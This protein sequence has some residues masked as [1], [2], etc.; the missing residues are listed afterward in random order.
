MYRIVDVKGG[1]HMDDK[2]LT[3]LKNL[4]NISEGSKLELI[5]NTLS[6]QAPL[7]GRVLTSIKIHRL[8]QRLK[9]HENKIND[10]NHR[11]EQ[12][13]DLDFVL[14]IKEF[15][16]PKVLQDLLDEDEDNKIAYF[17]DGFGQVID[18]EIYD[19][20]KI[21]IFYDILRTLRFIEI[22][23]LVSLTSQFKIYN[24]KN[25]HE[26]GNYP[27]SIFNKP[28]FQRIKYAIENKLESLG[29]IE[30]GRMVSYE[31][32]MD[33][34]DE[35]LKMSKRYSGFYSPRRDNTTEIAMFGYDFLNFF[36]ILD[37]YNEEGD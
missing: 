34:F 22:E 6:D 10:I 3:N 27:E 11:V 2:T 36:Y 19:K 16:L 4:M 26:H 15:L 17:L 9:K 18:N 32:V 21:L 31:E 29:L 1:I 5:F 28:D 8:G 30:T 37:V 7:I 33:R 35:E 24:M 23:Y 25:Y 12:I 14:L 13:G 20:S